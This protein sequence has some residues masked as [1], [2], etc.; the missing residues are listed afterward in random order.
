[1][2][3]TDLV[4]AFLPNRMLPLA[5][6][7][8]GLALIVGLVSRRRAASLVLIV[9]SIPV[10]DV[11][12]NALLSVV[13]AWLLVLATCVLAVQIL[14]SV[15]EF[16]VGRHATGHILGAIVIGAGRLALRTLGFSLRLV[17]TALVAVVRLAANRALPR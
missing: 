2:P 5:I 4:L 11:I 12:F 7:G 16:V 14:R 3:L 15:L 17:G 13:P 9:V 8:V 10:L 6:I 1:M